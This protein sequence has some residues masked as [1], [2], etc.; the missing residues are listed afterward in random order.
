MTK[1]CSGCR[2]HKDVE[3]FGFKSNNTEYKTCMGCRN[4]STQQSAPENIPFHRCS[5]D[6][7]KQTLKS[8]NCDIILTENI[9]YLVDVPEPIAC[10]IF[11]N[12]LIKNNGVYIEH[13]TPTNLNNILYLFDHLGLLN[14]RIFVS[15]GD[16]IIIFITED[17]T[18]KYMRHVRLDNIYANFIKNLKIKNSKRCD[19][20]NNKKKCFKVCGRCDHKHCS[21]CFKSNNNNYIKPCPFCRYTFVEHV[22]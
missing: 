9:E 15:V 12:L 7:I 18:L 8:Y 13:I 5:I 4:K 6:D 14:E 3:F 11:R 21:E 2:K 17:S 10:N 22:K 1:L 19:I 20:C 16:Y